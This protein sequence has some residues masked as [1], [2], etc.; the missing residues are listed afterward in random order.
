VSGT[1]SA[2]VT[3]LL[4]RWRGGDK[5]A[6]GQLIP[7]LYTELRK[8]ARRQLH[9]ERFEHTLESKGLVHEA[10]LRLVDQQPDYVENR[11]H[12]V[13]IA[14]ALMRQVLVD[15]ARRLRAAKRDG[16]CR[17]DLTHALDVPLAQDV[18]VVEIDDALNTLG[19]LD[20]RQAQIVEI[21]FFGGLSIEDTARVMGISPATVKREWVT[22]RAWLIRELG[23]AGTT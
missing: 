11:N 21:R 10:Y 2:T 17:I 20:A 19:A 12:F 14:S 15:H 1:H 5:A 23:P 8:I 18:D 6:L 7:Q 16:G 9:N 3:A 13:G 22:A 4:E